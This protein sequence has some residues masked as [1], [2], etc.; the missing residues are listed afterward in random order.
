MAGLRSLFSDDVRV[1]VIRQDRELE[2]GAA[3]LTM[4]LHHF[5]RDVPLVDVHEACA[6]GRDGATALD[7]A[8]AGRSYHLRVHALSLDLEG[9]ADIPCPAI[10]HWGFAHFVVLERFTGDG[11]TI[12]DPGPGRRRVDRDELSA[13]FTGVAL[14]MTPGDGFEP[15]AQG[16]EGEPA[17]QMV[18]RR[19]FKAP[20]AKR[21]VVQ[22][23]LASLFIQVLGLAVPVLTKVV[24]DGVLP[25]SIDDVMP[26]LGIGILVLMGSQLA[27]GLLRGFVLV[28]LQTRL[29][30][31]LMS[32]FLDHV[33]ALPYP[34]FQERSTGDLL[35]RLSS[36]VAIRNVLSNHTLVALIDGFMVV[37][38]GLI[39]LATFTPMGFAAVVLGIVQVALLVATAK[40][41]TALVI[42]ELA[43]QA[44]A[45]SVLVESIS[46]I[47]AVK[48]A[49]AEHR[50]LSHWTGVFTGQLEATMERGRLTVVLVATTQTLQRFAPLLLLWF[51]AISVLNGSMTLGT[52]L[53]L[54][55]LSQLFLGP[56]AA[57]VTAGL[58]FQQVGGHLERIATVLRVAPE[59]AGRQL[60]I[61]PPL[62]GDIRFD[63]VSFRYD[64][65]APWAVRDFY[66]HVRPGEMV[67]LVGRTGSGKSSVA[68]LLLGLYEPTQGRVHLDDQPLDELDLRSVRE[69]CGVVMQEPTVFN[70][71]VRRNIAY[72]DHQIPLDQVQRAARLAALH[73]EISRMPMGYD[74][75][76]AEGGSALSGG[77]RQ[78]LA[79]ARALVRNP[80]ILVLDEATSALD[81]ETEATVAAHLVEQGAASLVIAHRLSTVERAD[82]ILVLDQGAVVERGTH[83]ELIAD[84]GLY[85]QLVQDQMMES[86][87]R[88][89]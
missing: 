17:W 6:V 46:G 40:R 31:Q 89:G 84:G 81:S 47:E 33:L 52:M 68:K 88:A 45:E 56:L 5:G 59:Q 82:L 32:G 22:V 23:L 39:L 13:Q 51:G 64:A 3:C 73:E 43:E 58:M 72:N 36:N 66:L 10:L 16:A 67:A 50:T 27:L 57:L 61:A 25:L 63:N 85:Y 65:S 69:Q 44:A 71:S 38:Y 83:S 19:A 74:T 37:I 26:I 35:H 34:F 86:Q 7:I 70:G 78:R 12:V 29:D 77:Q 1:P 14:A 24:I 20:G 21:L 28:N 18:G 8:N 9:L 55:S 2:C 54:V 87:E 4:V 30:G 15:E 75:I 80:R 62:Q 76:I 42:K 79:I 41:M 11:A 48:A 60:R 53:A 49:G